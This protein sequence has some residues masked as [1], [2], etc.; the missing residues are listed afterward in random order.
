MFM[1]PAE[2]LPG[3]MLQ[4]LRFLVSGRGTVAQVDRRRFALEANWLG[5]GNRL[6][7]LAVLA[8]PTMPAAPTFFLNRAMRP[9]DHVQ[10]KRRRD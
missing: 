6:D 10:A 8:N 4:W 1:R 5:G 2:P 9:S 7:Q 3:Q